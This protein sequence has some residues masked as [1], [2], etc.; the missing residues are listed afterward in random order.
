[1]QRAR[2]HEDPPAPPCSLSRALIT[3]DRLGL[4]Y[5][6]HYG[7][8]DRRPGLC[9]S[10]YPASRTA[11]GMQH[12]GHSINTGAGAQPGATAS[13]RGVKHWLNGRDKRP[14]SPAL[15]GLLQPKSPA[16]LAELDLHEDMV[17][18]PTAPL[19]PPGVLRPVGARRAGRG[20]P[21]GREADS[22]S[23][24]RDRGQMDSGEAPSF[25]PSLQAGPSA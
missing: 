10:P 19:R 22:G 11:P 24:K 1:M 25:A 16:H 4:S 14:L 20:A 12:S 8:S 15:A 2:F 13:S 17:L 3:F 23:G 7:A 9:P 5:S 6:L 18:S 21:G